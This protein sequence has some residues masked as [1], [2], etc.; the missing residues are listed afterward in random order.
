MSINSVSQLL[1]LHE[2][3][4]LLFER[5]SVPFDEFRKTS[6]R[7]KDVQLVDAWEAFV[8]AKERLEAAIEAAKT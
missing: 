7:I 5:P 4:G 8:E 3:G 1:K 6:D 2:A